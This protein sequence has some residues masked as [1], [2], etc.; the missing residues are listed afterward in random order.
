MNDTNKNEIIGEVALHDI[1]WI[2]KNFY[3]IEFAD[4]LSV[5]DLL[6]ELP[7]FHKMQ[8][9]EK[10]SKLPQSLVTFFDKH[11]SDNDKSIENLK[12]KLIFDFAIGKQI[13]LLQEGL[14]SKCVRE[15]RKILSSIIGR[16]VHESLELEQDF[17]AIIDSLKKINNID[18]AFLCLSKSEDTNKIIS[19]LMFLVGHFGIDNVCVV[20]DATNENKEVLSIVHKLGIPCDTY[21]GLGLL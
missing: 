5:S 6:N 21:I 15:L 7:E 17:K 3:S 4:E 19:I 1:R 16:E 12:E 20:Y 18:F 2:R 9:K 8:D 11:Y 14:E 13:L 10:T